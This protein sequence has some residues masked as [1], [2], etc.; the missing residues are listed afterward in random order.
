[1][2]LMEKIQSFVAQ[3]GYD[4]RTGELETGDILNLTTA[5]KIDLVH[6]LNGIREEVAVVSAEI[7]I[8]KD[9]ESSSNALYS[10][11]KIVA[12]IDALKQSIIAEA[13]E[14]TD[15]LKEIYDLLAANG[16]ELN[17]LTTKIGEKVRYDAAQALTAEQQVQASVNIGAGDILKD[18]EATYLIASDV[19]TFID[20]GFVRPGF[21]A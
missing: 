4:I 1:M 3:V 12:L 7:P 10:S 11:V 5:S 8:I 18:F 15:T 13:P 21:V 17:D 14:A 2:P 19:N 6:A 20:P 9:S 16:A